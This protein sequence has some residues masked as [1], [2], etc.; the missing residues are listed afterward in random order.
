MRE[1]C[2]PGPHAGVLA[3]SPHVLSPRPRAEVLLCLAGPAT[4]PTFAAALAAATGTAVVA[5]AA[6]TLP[7]PSSPDSVISSPKTK[8]SVI[9]QAEW[10]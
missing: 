5:V 1:L 3:V 8:G 2:T 6:L 9:P 4:A 7:P 10:S